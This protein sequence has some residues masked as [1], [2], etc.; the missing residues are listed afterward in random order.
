MPTQL[1]L[2]TQYERYLLKTFIVKYFK[3][4]THGVMI[5]QKSAFYI[6]GLTVPIREK[7]T[8]TTKADL[9]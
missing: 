8:L 1:T 4:L 6:A 2:I 5:K 9:V 7:Y 3:I